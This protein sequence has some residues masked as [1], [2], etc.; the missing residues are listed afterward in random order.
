MANCRDGLPSFYINYSDDRI[1]LIED[2]MRRNGGDRVLAELA[3]RP[4]EDIL[5]A[6]CN[7]LT[8]GIGGVAARRGSTRHPLAAEN[9][10][11]MD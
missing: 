10:S 8:P 5:E 6:G 7:M 1:R 2:Q 9:G 3:T 11:A 4:A